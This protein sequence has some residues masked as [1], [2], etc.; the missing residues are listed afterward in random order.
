MVNVD[1]HIAYLCTMSW[2]TKIKLTG[3]NNADGT[4]VELGFRPALL[5]R[6]EL[7][8]RETADR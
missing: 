2:I 7:V 6:E 1:T 4:F 8:V 3:N 5:A